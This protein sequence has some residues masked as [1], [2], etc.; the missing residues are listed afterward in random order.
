MTRATAASLPAGLPAN[1]GDSD[2]DP[3]VV[4]WRA[5]RYREGGSSPPMVTA[6][7]RLRAGLAAALEAAARACR[8]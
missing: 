7:R 5:A 8:Q 2:S 3:P 6:T 4:V 1:G